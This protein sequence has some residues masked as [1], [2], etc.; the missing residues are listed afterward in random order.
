LLEILRPRHEPL[1]SLAVTCDF[2]VVAP[3]GVFDLF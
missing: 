2:V 3:E 1:S